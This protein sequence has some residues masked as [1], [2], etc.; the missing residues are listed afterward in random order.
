MIESQSDHQHAWFHVL[1]CFE[2]NLGV[3]Q[4][5][6]ILTTGGLVNKSSPQYYE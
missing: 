6:I 4:K 2:Q 5:I 3:T 1:S